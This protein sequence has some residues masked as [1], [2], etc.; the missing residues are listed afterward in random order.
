MKYKVPKM[1]SILTLAQ[2]LGLV[3]VV[4]GALTGTFFGIDL[5]E[6]DIAWLDK[7]KAYM[8]DTDKLF[9]LALILGLIHILFGMVLKVVNVSITKGFAYSYSTIG[10]LLLIVGRSEER[11][12]G[13]EC[14]VRW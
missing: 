14:R 13:K 1:R 8:I 11:R 10:W 2:W 4:F 12:V 9:N 6:A 3:T 5:I 7:W